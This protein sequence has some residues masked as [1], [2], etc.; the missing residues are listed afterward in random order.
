MRWLKTSGTTGTPKRV[1][2][3]LHWVLNY[4]IP[5]MKAMW[6]TY[7]RLHPELL[8]NPYA[9][10]DTQTVRENAQDYIHG[11]PF[12]A[13]SNRHPRMNSMDW[14]PPWY[15]APWF[16]ENAPVSFEDKMYCRVRHLVGKDLYFINAINPS[17]LLSLRDHIGTSKEKLVADVRN[18]TID[19]QPLCNADPHEADRLE[20]VLANPGFTLKDIWP[21]LGLYACWL[22]H[23][24]ACINKHWKKSFPASRGCRS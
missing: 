21:T 24:L 15:E 11:V 14:N 18:G 16:C 2:Y 19:G 6:G 17:T 13:V 5:A 7:S 20:K 9:T 23:P 12:Q 4:R 8:S 1:P 10:L 3:T 22:S